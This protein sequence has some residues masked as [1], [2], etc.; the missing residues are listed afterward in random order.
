MSKV[1]LILKEVLDNAA[2]LIVTAHFL[3]VY[4][5]QQSRT[6]ILVKF[7]EETDVNVRQFFKGYSEGQFDKEVWPKILKLKGWPASSLFGKQLPRHNADFI[8]CLPFKEYTH[9]CSGY[10]NLAVKLPKKSLTPDMG[11]KT[12]I[13]Y[14]FDEELGSGDSVTKL[15]CDMYDVVYALD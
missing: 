5:Q 11:P 15:H 6:T 9:P 8:S 4:G 14:G 10:L 3:I 12:H 2:F 1:F 7:V 13:A